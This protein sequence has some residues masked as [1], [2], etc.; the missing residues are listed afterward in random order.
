M[1][2]NSATEIVEQRLTPG[3]GPNPAP[4]LKNHA[5]RSPVALDG[6]PCFLFGMPFVVSGVFIGLVAIGVVAGKKGVPDWVMGVIGAL[7]FF[8]GLFL[9]IHG[10]LGIVRK[11]RYLRDAAQRPDQPWLYDFHWSQEGIAFSAFKTMLGRLV[12]ALLWTAFL[13]PFVWIGLNVRGAR[14][15]LYPS[16]VFALF[17]LIFWYRW[18]QMVGDL[19]RYGN[20]FLSYDNFP[21]FLGGTLRARLRAPHHVSDIEALT[22]T[23]RCVQEQYVTSGSGEARS[24]NVVCYELYNE[25]TTLTRERLASFAGGDITVEFRLPAGQ[26]TTSLASTPPVY[27][28]IEF[29]GGAGKVSYEAY[30]LVPVYKTS[31]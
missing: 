2:T 3:G 25:A 18:A 15:F 7:F 29:R 13:T 21:Y 9:V 10:F 24:T 20:S 23:L 22:V 27:W 12:A 17:G 11:A 16:L 6:W 19:V 28:E 8:S 5:T 4:I 31:Y 30:F 14:A 26:P 1:P